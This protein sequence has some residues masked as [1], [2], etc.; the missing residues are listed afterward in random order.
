MITQYIQ[1]VD[2]SALLTATETQSP[3]GKAQKRS[4][5]SHRNTLAGM[6]GIFTH[7]KESQRGVEKVG[8]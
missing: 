2:Y 4:Q 6:G 1:P 8:L 3:L 5:T 7:P